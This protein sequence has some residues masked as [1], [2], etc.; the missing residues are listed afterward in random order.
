MICTKLLSNLNS[1]FDNL[2]MSMNNLHFEID[3][4]VSD[5]F[6]TTA[7][8]ASCITSINVPG[9][10]DGVSIATIF[11]SVRSMTFH[12]AIRLTLGVALYFYF[13]GK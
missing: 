8:F 4:S 6:L 11:P 13:T 5:Q 7:S 9:D 12:H 3:S 10:G 1:R 2:L